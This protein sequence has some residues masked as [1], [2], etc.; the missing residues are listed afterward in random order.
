MEKC[1]VDE[2][3]GVGLL[4]DTWGLRRKPGRQKF[5]VSCLTFYTLSLLKDN[6][7]LCTFFTISTI[8]TG[9]FL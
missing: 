1:F 8:S 6:A 2:V 4:N 9:L 7:V 3:V 5:V